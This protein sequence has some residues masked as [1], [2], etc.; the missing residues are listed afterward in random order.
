MLLRVPNIFILADMRKSEV[1]AVQDGTQSL[2]SPNISEKRWYL[3]FSIPLQLS[4]QCKAKCAASALLRS[5]RLSELLAHVHHS[6]VS[7]LFQPVLFLLYCQSYLQLLRH[8]D[9][10]GG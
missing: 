2:I 5:L 10:C 8:P 1:S 4:I 7:V 9:A 3:C 6:K